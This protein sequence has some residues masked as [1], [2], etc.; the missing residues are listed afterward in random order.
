MKEENFETWDE[1][2]KELDITPEQEKE[3][4]L[5]MDI[6]KATIEVRKKAKLSQQELSEMSGIKQPNIAKLEDFK[7]TPQISTLIKLLYPMGYTLRVVPI[8]KK[9][10]NK[11]S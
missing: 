5:E 3:I 6:I 4:E 7:R 1:L 2:E 9:K 8:E 10:Y 11:K